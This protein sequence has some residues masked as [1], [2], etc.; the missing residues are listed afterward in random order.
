MQPNKDLT[1]VVVDDEPLARDLMCT[2]LQQQPAVTVLGQAANIREARQLI[3]LHQPDVVFLDIEM[4]GG[5]GF[6][7]VKSLQAD[8]MPLVVFATAFDQYAVAAFDLHAVDYLL[9]PLD[10]TRVAQSLE[11]ARSRKFTQEGGRKQLLLEAMQKMQGEPTAQV[12]SLVDG[13]LSIS[14]SGAVTLLPFEKIDWVDAA[15]DYMCVHSEGK[16]HVMR[17]TLK[18]LEEKLTGSSI[19]RVHRSTL[20]NLAKVTTISVLPKGERQLR[21]DS[22]AELKVSRNYRDALLPLQL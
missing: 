12:P 16:T 14:D 19:V 6:D 10:P 21:L 8:N 15:G 11:R 9:K 17:S 20:V 4:P 2:L 1:A 3:D 18:D 13:K 7:L 22:G 5:S